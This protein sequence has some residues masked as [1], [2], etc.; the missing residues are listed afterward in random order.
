MIIVKVR[1]I[2]TE[3]QVKF[4]L[5]TVLWARNIALDIFWL[6]SI[7]TFKCLWGGANCKHRIDAMH[8]LG[9]GRATQSQKAVGYRVLRMSDLTNRS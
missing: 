1:F 2:N 5:S 8:M 6:W 9:Y 3:T 4:L 7:C